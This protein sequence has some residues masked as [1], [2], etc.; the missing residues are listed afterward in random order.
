MAGA[1]PIIEMLTDESNWENEQLIRELL[2]GL[3][4][5]VDDANGVSEYEDER[6][7]EGFLMIASEPST[8]VYCL[9]Q[10]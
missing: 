7:V 3:L 4:K 10:R 9:I 8:A 6:V 5:K 1:N 2:E